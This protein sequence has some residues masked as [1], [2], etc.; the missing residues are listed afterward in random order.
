MVLVYG[1]GNGSGLWRR[2]WF[3]SMEEEMVPVYGGGNGSGLWRRKWFW[4]MEEEMVLVYGG[5]NGSGLSM[6][7]CIS[8]CSESS[9][10]MEASHK[11]NQIVPVFIV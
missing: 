9:C 11:P 5:G 1:G 4:S 3:R 7:T 10:M 6:H 8:A 2:K